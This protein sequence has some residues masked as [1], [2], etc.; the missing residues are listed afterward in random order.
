MPCPSCHRDVPEAHRFC[1]ACGAGVSP[2][3]A[4]QT[5]LPTSP[6]GDALA[7]RAAPPSTAVGRRF[8]PGTIV[9]NR[10]RIVGLLGRGGMGEVYRADDLKLG[11]PVALKFVPRAIAHDP[12]TRER[13]LAEVRM[14]RQVTHPNVCRVFD[15]AETDAEGG[16]H[17][18][19]MEYIDGEDLASLLRRIGR[20]PGDK[21]LDIARQV[22]AGL[23]A[24][25]Q[26]G[27]LHRDLKPA[28]VMLD[29]RGRAR[30]TDFGLA[31]ATDVSGLAWDLSGTPAYMAPEQLAGGGAS[32][33]SDVYALGLLLYELYTGNPA[34]GPA[35][36][37][38]LRARKEQD[39]PP[40]P[41]ERI[42]DMDPAVERVIMHAIAP[43]P[44]A[45]PASV[46]HVSAALPGGT[47]IEAA[48]RAGETPS[49]EMIAASGANEGLSAPAAWALLALVTI[50][51]IVAAVAVSR[52][53]LWRHSAPERPPEAMAADARRMLSALGYPDRPIDRAYGFELDLPRLRHL[54]A[55]MPSTWRLRRHDPSALRFWY[56]E[57]PQPLEAWR[58]PFQYGNVSRIAPADPPL[59]TAGM[60]RVRLDPDGLLTEL[61]VVPSAGATVGGTV[62]HP[63]WTTVLTRAGFEAEAWR[64]TGPG[65]SPPVY[66]D[67]RAAWDGTWP[68]APDLPVRLEAATLGGALVYFEAVFP[69]TPLPRAPTPV[70]SSTERAGLLL[71]LAM[72]SATIVAAVIAAQRN[73]RTGRGD[74]SGARRLAAFVFAALMTSWFFGESHVTTLWEVGLIV[75]ALAWASLAAGLCWV[76]YL[77]AEPFLRRHWPDV[78]VTWARVLQGDFRDPRIGR[79]VL[80]GC[81]A[82]P[83]LAALAM[84]GL[85][86]PVWSGVATNPVFID[87][88]GV[89]FGLQTV[90]PLLVWR[91]AQAVLSGLGIAF[92]LV[93]LRLALRSHRAAVVTFVIVGSLITSAGVWA[94]DWWIVLS[95]SVIH[96]AAFVW[97]IA[98][99][100]LLAFVAAFYVW[101]LLIFFP[102]TGD[103]DAWYAGAGLAALLTLYALTLFGV[104]TSQSGRPVP[105]VG[106]TA[107]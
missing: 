26:R 41:S 45:R 60:T 95:V 35:S 49:P 19:T 65:R 67:A 16:Q 29:G 71:A 81:A 68:T 20:L 28:N 10:Y 102:I 27:V 105:A 107:P 6:D 96:T 21:A 42:R 73:L 94:E 100:G 74:R 51:T 17:F 88:F 43:D 70:L 97:L 24:A 53:L 72:L 56:R 7:P 80:I 31:V 34:F 25:H 1:G 8:T 87:L 3:S 104:W 69:W 18:L 61:V 32:I 5:I 62:G 33:R 83:L 101:G 12:V 77:A 2:G 14:A 76:A 13:L 59:D 82:G 22:C 75:M 84:L 44:M 46:V 86:L 103:L 47:L 39:L 79:D 38:E 93:L 23:A 11:T 58:F 9:V 48:L 92:L 15:I 52:A 90:L 89:A 37:H 36:P 63:D 30:I 57:S 98:R 99:I 40:A 55:A 54:Q 91:A 66:A 50:G 64:A 78:M 4:V 106:T 85:M